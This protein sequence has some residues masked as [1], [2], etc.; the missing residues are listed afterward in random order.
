MAQQISNCK[1]MHNQLH[2]IN[3][4]VYNFSHLNFEKSRELIQLRLYTLSKLYHIQDSD[5]CYK[6]ICCFLLLLTIK[7]Y[8]VS[9]L[10]IIAKNYLKIYFKKINGIM[11]STRDKYLGAVSFKLRNQ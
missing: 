4:V 2:N 3:Y 7:I 10:Y 11:V 8:D 1:M 6:N 9:T 5:F